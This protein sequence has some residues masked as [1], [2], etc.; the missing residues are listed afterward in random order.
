MESLVVKV[1]ESTVRRFNELLQTSE[2]QR[3]FSVG[4]QNFFFL[5][6]KKKVVFAFFFLMEFYVQKMGY[7]VRYWMQNVAP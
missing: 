3:N 1:L 4:F 6:N 5:K 2:W 7:P